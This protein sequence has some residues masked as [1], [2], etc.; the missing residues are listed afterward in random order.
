MNGSSEPLL[1]VSGLS[2][3]MRAN[4]ERRLVEDVSFTLGKGETLGLV[5]ES[6]SGK[7]VTCQ[8]VLEV[9]PEALETT[10]GSVL[11][12]GIDLTS[13]SRRA[14][15][16]IRGKRIGMVFQDPLSSLNPALTVGHQIAESLKV[17]LGMSRK[18][19]WARAV[20]LLDLVS[21]PAP[22]LRVKNH[23][24]EMSGGMA[25]RALIAMAI[26]CEPDLLIAD[27]PTTA[28]DVT[29][30]LQILDLLKSVQEELG[31]ALL[32]VSHDLGVITR[33]SEQVA[34]MYAGQVIETGATS[35]VFRD[36]Q[37]PYTSALISSSAVNVP[38]GEPLTVIRGQVPRPADVPRNACRF[39]NRCD[40]VVAACVEGAPVLER[41]GEGR[42]TR[43][44]RHAELELGGIGQTDEDLPVHDEGKVEEAQ[45]QA[46]LQVNDLVKHFGVRTLGLG[47]RKVHAVDDVDLTVSAGRI[48]GLVGE[49]GSGKSTVARLAL[50]LI[51][52]T[53]GRV[54]VLGQD[55]GALR[56][57]A[58][59]AQRK[60]MQ[61]VFQDP[62]GTLDPLLTVGQSI[63]EPMTVHFNLSDSEE[64]ERVHHL[65]DRVG[66]DPILAKRYP[67][68]LSGGQRQ[69]VAIA[70][71]L[72]SEPTLIVCDEAVSALDVSTRAQII[73][74]I[75][76][77]KEKE[78]IGF[79]FISHDLATVH[80]VSDDIAVMY[81]GRVVE[82]GPATRVYRDP[83]H[84][85]TQA[86]LSSILAPNS[87]MRED[88]IEAIG[89]IP[90]PIDPPSGC[91]FRTRCPLAIDICST[92]V[93]RQVP[94][95]GGGW[96]AC[97]LTEDTSGVPT[98]SAGLVE[99]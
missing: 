63:S 10:G 92:D 68:A 93:P 53:A 47:K 89:E 54:E 55:L 36:P 73:N 74:L 91:R 15:N 28:L 83:Q 44:I 48:L 87:E 25:Q 16:Q 58:L 32:L 9:L 13:V 29:I 2:V 60:H 82:S 69:R 30:Q 37:H 65:L 52:P 95:A 8:A 27:E 14:L 76:D 31:M 17:H 84:P 19:A 42:A 43:C 81:L 99:R 51:N 45:Q 33:M 4:P 72:A 46:A 96:S 38:K 79:L 24:H 1:E 75:Q 49:S 86:L 71:A 40:H 78:G 26:A 64:Q 11:F 22:H 34:V 97:H 61:M 94:V 35:E 39:N 59:R 90:S 3:S 57:G 77:L 50:R 23:P 80:H 20:E 66:L 5:G 18:Q 21:I 56:G 88:A 62:Y 12:D 6:G 70:R 85:Y 98:E 7:S 67:T 41:L